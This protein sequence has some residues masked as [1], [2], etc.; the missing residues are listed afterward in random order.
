MAG[1][2][3]NGRDKKQVKKVKFA[4]EQDIKGQRESRNIALL[5][6]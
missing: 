4:L 3:T 1:T 6:L 5:F 2:G